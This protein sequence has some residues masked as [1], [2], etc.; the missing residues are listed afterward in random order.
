MRALLLGSLL[1]LACPE[2]VKPKV[3]PEVVVRVNGEAVTREDFERELLRE[4]SAMNTA[5]HT[6]EQVEPYKKA[7]LDTVVE[8]TLLL[9]AARDAGV[10]VT[11]D[12]VDRRVLALVA[13]Y[14]AEGFDAALVQSQT[15]RGALNRETR[16]QLTIEKLFQEQ[17][18][19]RAAVTEDSINRYFEEHAVEFSAL[20]EV[21]AQQIVVKGLDE[22]KRLKEQLWAGKKFGDLARK[23]SLSPDAKV[24]GDLGWFPRGVMPSQFDDVVF[25]L[26]VNQVS[27]VVSTDY[28][29]HLLKVLEKRPAR[30]K[31]LAEVRSMIEAKLLAAA[32]ADGQQRFVQQLKAKAELK[33][34]DEVLLAVTGRPEAKR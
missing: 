2:Q 22:A 13:E 12:E 31:E 30:K 26:G 11:A 33:V 5:P 34:N 16:T 6:P 28:G 21:H 25:R 23:F 18:Y 27:D 17:V 9:Q 15:T 24:G 32:R 4:L 29:F 14:P 19:A 8:R 10:T 1:L 7:L 20:E 3:D